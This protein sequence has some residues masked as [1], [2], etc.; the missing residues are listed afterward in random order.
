MAKL[1]KNINPQKNEV[2]EKIVIA[3]T[4]SQ[5]KLSKPQELMGKGEITFD[6]YLECMEDPKY[7]QYQAIFSDRQAITIVNGD[8]SLINDIFIADIEIIKAFGLR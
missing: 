5:K 4:I 2:I 3:A 6:D 8:V 7:Y 1:V